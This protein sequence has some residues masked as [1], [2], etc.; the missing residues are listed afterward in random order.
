M[1]RIALIAVAAFF[2]IGCAGVSLSTDNSKSNWAYMTGKDIGT[3]VAMKDKSF[4]ADAAVYAEGVLTRAKAGNITQSDLDAVKMKLA[5]RFAGDPEYIAAYLLFQNHV[6]ITLEPG[7]V[8]QNLVDAIQGFMD[9]L[10]II[11]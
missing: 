7:K 11:Q 9:G 6:T 3:I 1:K 10:K 2:L 8:D 5:S 4:A